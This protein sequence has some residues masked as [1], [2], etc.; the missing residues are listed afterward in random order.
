[1]ERYLFR[2]SFYTDLLLIRRGNMAFSNQDPATRLNPL[3]LIA[4]NSDLIG[5]NIGDPSLAQIS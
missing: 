4:A 5:L 1:M 3:D 2:L